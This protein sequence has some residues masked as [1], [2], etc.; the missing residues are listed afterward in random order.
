MFILGS[1]LEVAE[2]NKGSETDV[3]E[4][5]S[6]IFAPET[7]VSIVLA[8]PV[9]LY[10]NNARSPCSIFDSFCHFLFFII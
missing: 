8:D 9:K 6:I 10:S 3:I 1:I 7:G 4:I 5:S 2:N